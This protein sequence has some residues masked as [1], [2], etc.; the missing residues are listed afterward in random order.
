[1]IGG[2]VVVGRDEDLE[3]VALSGLHQPLDVLDGLVL[4]YAVAD[5]CPSDALLTQEIVL[6]IGNQHCCIVLVDSNVYLVSPLCLG[7]HCPQPVGLPAQYPD[8][9]RQSQTDAREQ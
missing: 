7:Q 9:G 5:Q 1:M 8:D 6:R 2:V 4:L 3:P